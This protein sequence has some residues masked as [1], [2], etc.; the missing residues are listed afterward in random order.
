MSQHINIKTLKISTQNTAIQTISY[1]DHTLENVHTP[2]IEP[3]NLEITIDRVLGEGGMGIVYL[4]RQS[5]PK[6]DV[7]IKR[8]KK[9]NLYLRKALY[10][11]AMITG[12]LSHPT[13][14]P[15]YVLNLEGSAS[16]EVI[17]K[18]VEG[19]NMLDL[20]SKKDP[21]SDLRVLLNALQQVCNG[22][23]YAHS[24]GI[25]HRDIKPENIMLGEFGEVYILDWGIAAQAEET[26]GFP[27]VMVGTPA[28]MAPEMLSGDPQNVDEK[29]DVYLLGATLHHILTGKVRHDE[30]TMEDI[31][32][33]ILASEA[34]TYH[35]HVPLLLANLANKACHPDPQN[36]IQSPAIFRQKLQE[37]FD[38]SQA[39][40]ISDVAQ[41]E[42][43]VLEELLSLQEWTKEQR[44]AIQQHYNRSRFGFE[45]ALDIWPDFRT[46]KNLL[47][48]TKQTMIYFYLSRNNLNAAKPLIEEL[49][50][51]PSNLKIM[52]EQLQ[53]EQNTIQHEIELYRK[54]QK[55]KQSSGLFRTYF[56]MGL[57]SVCCIVMYF[58]FQ[59]E[60]IDANNINP[61]TLFIQ[62]TTML[63]P[64]VP[65]IIMGR[66]R[67]LVSP[68]G[69]RAILA[70]VG[71]TMT[72]ILH[73]WISMAHQELPTSIIATDFFIFG[74]G[75]SN[76][77]PSVRH[78]R[79]LGLMCIG[80]GI[81]GHLFPVTIWLGTLISMVVVGLCL[82]GDWTRNWNEPNTKP[83]LQKVA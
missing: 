19:Q 46:A 53:N 43:R 17:M 70:V 28:Y 49:D 83:K 8:L 55:K 25:I 47:S 57:L 14:I 66:N 26:F 68:N 60:D 33:Q 71:L 6:R 67:F 34:Y 76:M 1:A 7:A 12:S 27:K 16:P 52:I 9:Q 29:T 69:K 20:I 15:I 3:T 50:E 24:R 51:I 10:R 72:V 63:V 79:A 22:L 73:R 5:H 82:Y 30:E 64:L 59:I 35:E 44:N 65:L 62:S 78:G 38:Y 18:R 31:S 45:Q 80:I 2:K 32:Q 4:G 39:F 37:Y 41:K 61:E 21:T 58:L 56:A 81:I 36:R 48:K 75:L 77:V 54:D 42:M 11:E 13:I 23:E 40:S 74:F